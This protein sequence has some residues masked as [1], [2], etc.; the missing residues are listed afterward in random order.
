MDKKEALTEISPYL[1]Q[2]HSAIKNGWME[3]QTQYKEVFHLHASWTR[4]AII[5]DHI[6]YHIRK[7]FDG[8]E[9]VKLIQMK[10][11]LFLI[12]IKN[13]LL[14]FKKLDTNYCSS[15]IPTDQSL[16]FVEQKCL[17]GI[18]ESI[19]FNVGYI[20]NKHWTEINGIYLTY[21][22]GEK[23]IHWALDLNELVSGRE[24]IIEYPMLP[25]ESNETKKRV[26]AK[27]IQL[28]RKNI[29]QNE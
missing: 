13:F 1:P 14:R 8:H 16:S 6:V 24:K 4:P 7:H 11:G 17:P 21:P 20:P 23:D 9:H 25:Y 26:R 15:N 29:V 27:T 3:Y 18:K 2:I 28:P 22:K 5:R 19:N 12:K 10:N